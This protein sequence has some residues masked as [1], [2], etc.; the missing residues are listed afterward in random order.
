MCIKDTLSNT[1][2]KTDLVLNAGCGISRMAEEMF[3]DGY[4]R[5]IS[6][7]ISPIAVKF[8]GDKCRRKKEE[9]K[10]SFQLQR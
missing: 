5:V 1:I 7:D 2:R 10:C 4:E 6:I 8:M 3:E 9:F